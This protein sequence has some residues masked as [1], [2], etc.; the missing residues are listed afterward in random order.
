MTSII[1]L[2]ICLFFFS[3]ENIKKL[4][5]YLMKV[6]LFRYCVHSSM[7]DGLSGKMTIERRNFSWGEMWGKR[8]KETQIQVHSNIHTYTTTTETHTCTH[9]HTT[10]HHY[11]HPEVNDS[12]TKWPDVSTIWNLVSIWLLQKFLEQKATLGS[13]GNLCLNFVTLTYSFLR[14]GTTCGRVK[15]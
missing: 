10:N 5:V 6:P 11:H 13:I 7:F 2:Y 3:C 8:I 15:L 9:T 1:T 14:Q 12:R 4:L